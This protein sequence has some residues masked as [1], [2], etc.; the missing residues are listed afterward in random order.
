MPTIAG[1]TPYQR[2]IKGVVI[3]SI[4]SVCKLSP[5]VRGA[6][7]KDKLW[8][9]ILIAII[10]GTG[11]P[12]GSYAQED[13]CRIIKLVRFRDGRL[14]SIEWDTEKLVEIRDSRG[15]DRT[16]EGGV[17]EGE[18][19][20]SGRYVHCGKGIGVALQA[21]NSEIFWMNSNTSAQVKD[22]FILIDKG[23]IYTRAKAIRL[24]LTDER[25]DWDV[26]GSPGNEFYLKV[27]QREPSFIYLFDGSIDIGSNV[28]NK[29]KPLAQI[30]AGQIRPYGL[31]DKDINEDP[32]P[33]VISQARMWRKS[34]RR[35][36]AP[37]WLKPKFYVPTAAVAAG[38]SAAVYYLTREQEAEVSIHIGMP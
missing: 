21:S 32:I 22:E 26:I 14:E 8:A 25:G 23:E 27:G 16:P 15:R 2:G 19:I 1:I 31:G 3:R 7:M 11:L 28:L 18:K 38:V 4:L 17:I 35:L 29:R 6:M 20:T 9:V 13:A 34:I 36:T 37:F 30:D 5:K 33:Q 10:L 24:K 12:I